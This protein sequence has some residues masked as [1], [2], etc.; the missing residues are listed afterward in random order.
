MLSEL[1]L[2]RRTTAG[3]RLEA[4]AT[5]RLGA[6]GAARSGVVTAIVAAALTFPAAS[7]AS[8]EYV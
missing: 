8:M 3:G 5:S 4:C 1:A 2:Q 7:Y 6:E